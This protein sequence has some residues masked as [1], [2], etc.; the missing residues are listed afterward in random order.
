MSNKFVRLL[1]AL[2][3]TLSGSLVSPATSSTG[4]LEVAGY[5]LYGAVFMAYTG[6]CGGWVRDV[7]Q[8]VYCCTLDQ[9]PTCD[10]EGNC[11]CDLDKYC[12]KIC[13]AAGNCDQKGAG[14]PEE[15]DN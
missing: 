13:T 1:A 9:R 4:N 10:D 3:L 2:A 8:D 14:C 15:E 5:G 12:Y 11:Q 6:A 7:E